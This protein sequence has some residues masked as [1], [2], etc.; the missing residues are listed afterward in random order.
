MT[1]SH[2]PAPRWLPSAV[3][4]TCFLFALIG[5]G[6]GETFGVFLLP[7]QTA[8][9][10][11]RADVTGIYGVAALAVGFAG[12]I[13]GYLSD[14][15]GPRW[16]YAVGAGALA[17]AYIGAVFATELWHFYLAL[18]IC[19]GFAS[20][21]LGNVAQTPLIAIWF[22]GRV[23]TVLGIIGGATGIGALVFAP[24]SQIVIEKFGYRMSYLVLAGSAL[25]LAVPL[26]TLPWAKI[27]AGR[28]G[29]GVGP[30]AVG[31]SLRHAAREPV[32]WAMFGV[33]FLTSMAI[34][35]IQPQMVA[36]LVDVGFAP[37][38][39]ASAAGFAGLSASV[40]MVLFGWMADRIGRRLTL[41]LSYL[42][43]AIGLGVLALMAV[44]P[45]LWLLVLYVL[46]FGLSLGS[47][48]P[49]IASLAQRIYAGSALGRVLG[50]LLIGMGTGTASGAWIGGSL[51]DHYGNY[52]AGFVVSWVAIALALAPWWLSP[53]LRRL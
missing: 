2:A 20:T 4:S 24:M 1:D 48:G 3:L 40:G 50:F 14:H 31:W 29:S 9:G 46:T 33:Y 42:S 32:L 18:G 12:P 30:V 39:A 28:D 16:L 6:T 36:Y 17:A 52:Q 51:H 10:W 25:T 11:D 49:L 43:T 26:A 41:S 5:R 23:G 22:K 45:S 44:W 15:L 34:S 13:A 7:L 53:Q 8:F 19:A 37:L 47:R 21:C 27:A 38:T 35:I